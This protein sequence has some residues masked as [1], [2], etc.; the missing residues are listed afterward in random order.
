MNVIIGIWSDAQQFRDDNYGSHATINILV[1]GLTEKSQLYV[2]D[3]KQHGIAVWNFRDK[4]SLETHLAMITAKH[5]Y[6]QT[7]SSA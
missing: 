6:L 4:A 1:D 7:N 3:L 2:G 5:E